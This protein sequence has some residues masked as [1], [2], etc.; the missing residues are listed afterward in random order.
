MIPVTFQGLRSPSQ[1]RPQMSVECF[2]PHRHFQLVEGILHHVVRIQ[3]VDLIDDDLH[4]AR[5]GVGKEQKFGAGQRL[6]A[7]QSEL[8]RLEVFQT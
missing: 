4:V 2:A 1:P 7:C 5:H 6:E 3:F 8:V